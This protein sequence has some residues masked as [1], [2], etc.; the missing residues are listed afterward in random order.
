MSVH[1]LLWCFPG[2]GKWANFGPIWHDGRLEK[3]QSKTARLRLTEYRKVIAL[4]PPFP[5]LPYTKLS[6]LLHSPLP[7]DFASF[8]SMIP[9]LP[10]SYP[11]KIASSVG[12]RINLCLM[13]LRRIMGSK[14]YGIRGGYWISNEGALATG[15]Q[16]RPLSWIWAHGVTGWRRPPSVRWN[17]EL[18]G[19]WRGVVL[20]VQLTTSFRWLRVCPSLRHLWCWGGHMMA[21]GQWRRWSGP[22]ARCGGSGGH[23]RS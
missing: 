20:P 13:F 7:P 23:P 2:G 22:V 16:W 6:I 8:W 4:S 9:V 21:A 17:A 3:R 11:K 15:G 10:K 1:G 18:A 12:L 19:R 5:M 14:K